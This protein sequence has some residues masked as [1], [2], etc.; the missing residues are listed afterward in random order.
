MVVAGCL[1]TEHGKER[2]RACSPCNGCIVFALYKDRP[3]DGVSGRECSDSVDRK[4]VF[5][6]FRRWI[7][8]TLAVEMVSATEIA[9]AWGNDHLRT[10]V[11]GPTELVQLL[12]VLPGGCAHTDVRHG[13]T[14][15][16]ITAFWRLILLSS[17]FRA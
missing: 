7:L 10:P 16:L 13:W 17:R 4:T 15:V 5:T 8:A 12:A 1:E 3:I 14:A 9:A 2:L 11:V 6:L